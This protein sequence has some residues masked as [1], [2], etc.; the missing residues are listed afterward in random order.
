M[1]QRVRVSGVRAERVP[2]PLSAL[3]IEGYTTLPTSETSKSLC[4][5]APPLSLSPSICSSSLHPNAKPRQ[6]PVG[7]LWIPTVL[8]DSVSTLARESAGEEILPE[9]AQAAV[10]PEPDTLMILIH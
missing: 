7:S 8:M 3:S 6:Y 10:S 2:A 5:E 4:L 9:L 1:A